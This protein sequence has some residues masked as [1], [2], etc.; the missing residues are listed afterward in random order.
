MVSERKYVD[1]NLLLQGLD[2]VANTFKVSVPLSPVGET[3]EETT[4]S[5]PT[6]ELQKRLQLLEK[7]KILK[8]A[9]LIEIGKQLTSRLFP[10][11]EI[12]KLFQRAIDEAGAE[13]S[14]RLRLIINHPKLAQLP[15]ESA[16]PNS[17]Y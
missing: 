4:V 15:W 17:K 9:P 11:E 16:I 8:K 7:R 6:E 10:S 14:V 12:R 2:L 5:Y 13:G 3:R 1:F